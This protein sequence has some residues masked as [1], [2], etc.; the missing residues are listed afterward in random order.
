ML[1]NFIKSLVQ[2]ERIAWLIGTIIICAIIYTIFVKFAILLSK[3]AELYTNFVEIMH[4]KKLIRYSTI[5]FISLFVAFWKTSGV[6][7]PKPVKQQNML[8]KMISETIDEATSTVT[9]TVKPK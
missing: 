1:D 6:E 4:N 9:T 8:V 5:I 7:K 3:I 2:P